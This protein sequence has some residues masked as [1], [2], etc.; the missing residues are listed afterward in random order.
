MFPISVKFSS[1]RVRCMCLA[2]STEES[3]WNESENL[4]GDGEDARDDDVKIEPRSRDNDSV[5]QHSSLRIA[6][7][8][9]S[10]LLSL[11]IREPIYEV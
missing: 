8:S 2:R 10:D 7:G 11:G 1:P 9:S 3:Q 4:A 5:Q 6:T